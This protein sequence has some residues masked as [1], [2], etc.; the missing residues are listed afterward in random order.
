MIGAE[1]LLVHVFVIFTALGARGTDSHREIVLLKD[2]PCYPQPR[3]GQ[4][5]RAFLERG[6]T[7]T[8]DSVATDSTSRLWFRLAS[9]QS[10]TWIPGTAVR[11]VENI[12]G[13]EISSPV[14]D[15]RD[16]RKRRYRILREHRDWPRRIQRAIR[17]GVVCLGMSREQLTASW[18]EP[19]Q[20]GKAWTLGIGEYQSWFYRGDEG[21]IVYVCLAEDRVIGWYLE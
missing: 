4:L 14:H 20:K 16:A 15:D 5:P 10:G 8:V 6:D 19:F 9:P 3:G 12:D 18:G 2:A 21:Q 13:G 1:R 7:C 11:Y 17:E